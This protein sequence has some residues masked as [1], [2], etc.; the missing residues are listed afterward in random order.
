MFSL[1]DT[2]MMSNMSFDSEKISRKLDQSMRMRQVWGWVSRKAIGDTFFA[3]EITREVEGLVQPPMRHFYSLEQLELI[4]R[5]KP[6]GRNPFTPP[7]E[8]INDE[9]WLPVN[10]LLIEHGVVV[11]SPE[12]ANE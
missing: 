7:F 1:S 11:G 4:G 10:Q 12:S 5:Q 2:G 3:I 6:I 9:L 8:K